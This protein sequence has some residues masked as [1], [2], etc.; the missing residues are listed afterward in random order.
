MPFYLPS[1]TDQCDTQPAIFEH[2]LVVFDKHNRCILTD[3]EYEVCVQERHNAN[4]KTFSPKK[5]SSWDS[6]P[7]NYLEEL[8]KTDNPINHFHTKPLLRFRSLWTK[9]KCGD[10]VDR[11]LPITIRKDDHIIANKENKPDQIHNKTNGENGMLSSGG[12]IRTNGLNNN[13]F[14]AHNNNNNNNS[15]IQNNNNNN[16]NPEAIVKLRDIASRIIYHFT[17]NN[18][19]SQQTEAVDNFNCPWCSLHCMTLYSLLKHLKL[20]HARF[21][22]TYVPMQSGVRVDVSINGQFDGSYSGSP[23]DPVGPAGSAFS[24]TGPVRRISVTQLLVCHPRR[25]KPSLNEFLELDENEMNS[26]RPYITGHTRQYHHTMTCLPILPKELE[27]DSEDEND[28]AWL[29]H[30][31]MQMLDEFTDVNEGEKELMKMWNLHIM[32]K[33][34]V[35]DIQIPL[36][37]EM[38]MR[39]HGEEMLRKNLYKNFMLH[40]CNLFDYGLLSAEKHSNLVEMLQQRLADSIEGRRIMA[41]ARLVQIDYWKNVGIHRYREMQLQQQAQGPRK[42]AQSILAAAAAES[43]GEPSTMDEDSTLVAKE[44][45]AG[46]HAIN[47]NS[48]E[49]K[50][51]KDIRTRLNFNEH[52]PSGPIVKK[53]SKADMNVKESLH[54]RRK[55]TIPPEEED[56]K[57][58]KMAVSTTSKRKSSPPASGKSTTFHLV[59]ACNFF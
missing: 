25:T 30:K 40:L 44:R 6:I 35:G 50:T 21:N 10:Y 11:P 8:S 37:C 4:M 43:N 19:S 56:M 2:D 31:T 34:Y 47:G 18:N 20:C 46:S 53:M 3:G 23:Y 5:H 58:G 7:V 1:F 55:S 17:C 29:Q 24:A 51:R 45:A 39:A 12:T 13:S 33:G 16:N 49:E 28:P 14:H 22:F 42:N 57:R 59:H 36:A 38:F 32:R 15:N 48:K 52:K 54:K 27:N 9:E 41:N 26:Q